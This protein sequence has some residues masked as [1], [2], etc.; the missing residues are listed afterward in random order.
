MRG[1]KL[2]A[3]RV[4]EVVAETAQNGVSQTVSQSVG[5]SQQK[6]LRA[7][8]ATL[9]AIAAEVEQGLA[10]TVGVKCALSVNDRASVILELAPE[11]LKSFSPQQIA[12]AIE[13][14]NVEA[15]CDDDGKIHVGI[16]PWLTAKETDQTIL[17]I[18]K[19][20]HVLL[21]M[22]ATA[23]DHFQAQTFFGR[24]KIL[25]HDVLLLNVSSRK[26]F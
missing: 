23:D 14:E 3:W 26:R 1:T 24:F 2:L 4:P 12:E 5:N 6:L 20:T 10:E 17:V 15:W 19:V 16:N 7:T 9:A 13:M 18:V 8:H 25:L 11:N 21:G 22:H